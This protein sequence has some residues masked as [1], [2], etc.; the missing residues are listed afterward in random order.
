VAAVGAHDQLGMRGAAVREQHAT[1]LAEAI[2]AG[3]L[4]SYHARRNAHGLEWYHY[5]V[6][7]GADLRKLEA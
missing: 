2:V 7:H 6:G 5:T 3:A 4:E 1:F